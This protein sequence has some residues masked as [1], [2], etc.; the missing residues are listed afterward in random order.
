MPGFFTRL[1][2]AYKAAKNAEISKQYSKNGKQVNCSF[3]GCIEFEESSALLNT[4][5]ATFVNLD[6]TDRSATILIC[7]ECGYI[8]WWLPPSPQRH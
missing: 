2:R 6:W 5:G 1:K 4:R 3:C 8:Q 7:K